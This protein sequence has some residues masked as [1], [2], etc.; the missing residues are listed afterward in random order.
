ME[1]WQTEREREINRKKEWVKLKYCEK[2]FD[3]RLKMVGSGCGAVGRA[4]ASNSRGLQFKSSHQKKI[5]LNNVY[6]QLDWKD[7]NKEKE[8]G[9][10]PFLTKKD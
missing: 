7:K 5:I 6:C 8:A 4:V 3:K 2:E 9:N 1:V 10:G